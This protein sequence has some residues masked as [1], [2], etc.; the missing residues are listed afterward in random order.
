MLFSRREGFDDRMNIVQLDD[1]D[2][3][4]RNGIWNC[5]I[6]IYDLIDDDV[7]SASSADS[8]LLTDCWENV[9]KQ[10]IDIISDILNPPLR[11]EFRRQY[12]DAKWFTV[13]DLIEYLISNDKNKRRRQSIKQ[14]CN[15]ILERENAGYRIID[16][17][18]CPIISPPEIEEIEKAIVNPRSEISNH[19]TNAIALLS[20]KQNPDFRNSIKESISAVESV[21]KLISHDSHA[22][23][24]QA[25][26]EIENNGQLELNPYFK[27]ALQKLY[28]WTNDADGIRHALTDTPTVNLAHARFMLVTSSAIVNYL[29]DEA[30]RRGIELGY[31]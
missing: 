25:L 8:G 11:R 17:T 3:P 9:F 2:E 31:E 6:K 29:Q 1:I 5:L 21:C 16:N 18:V 4:L 27:E 14:C 15:A 20:D 12:Y 30:A 26:R 10:P 19:L 24:G 23:L 13:Y 28:K 22:S 7:I